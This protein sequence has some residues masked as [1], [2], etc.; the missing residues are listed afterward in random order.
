MWEKVANSGFFKFAARAKTF[1]IPDESIRVVRS[2]N[3]V[4]MI[5]VAC[6][7]FKAVNVNRETPKGVF[8]SG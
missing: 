3:F 8:F 6:W 5:L 4:I 1:R 7:N 2:A